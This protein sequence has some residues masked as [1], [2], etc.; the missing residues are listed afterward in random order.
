MSGFSIEYYVAAIAVVF[1]LLNFANQKKEYIFVDRPDSIV[2]RVK[3]VSL[4]P[5]NFDL[6]L[7]EVIRNIG[8]E[9]SYV[10]RNDKRLGTVVKVSRSPRDGWFFGR[11]NGFNHQ[12][13][14]IVP[15]LSLYPELSKALRLA[16]SKG[17]DL[18][19]LGGRV[20]IARNGLYRRGEPLS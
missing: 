19:G 18:K 9:S 3:K 1:V 2:E 4:V 13:D 17:G 16:L 20:S 10:I 7:A 6:I 11:N 8:P 12:E 15:D 14:R 5:Y